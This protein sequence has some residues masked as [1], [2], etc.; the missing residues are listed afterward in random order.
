MAN[1]KKYLKAENHKGK[2]GLCGEAGF[3]NGTPLSFL[4]SE[5]RLFRRISGIEKDILW[6]KWVL[7]L[8]WIPILINL[9]LNFL[10]T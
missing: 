2:E 10:R 8:I 4:K 9:A 7:K 3:L 6:I 5:L 1:L